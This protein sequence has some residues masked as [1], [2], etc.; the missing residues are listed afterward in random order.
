M[1]VGKYISAASKIPDFTYASSAE[2]QGFWLVTTVIE[3]FQPEA[4]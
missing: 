3:K 2:G 4:A 1:R